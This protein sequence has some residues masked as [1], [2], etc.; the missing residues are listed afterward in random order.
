LTICQPRGR[1]PVAFIW[2]TP[3]RRTRW[4]G[5]LAGRR[6]LLYRVAARLPVRVSTDRN[7]RIRGSSA[8]FFVRHYD[9]GG[10]LRLRQT[11]AAHVAG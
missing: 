10:R 6:T 7:V 4:I 2:V 3:R 11:I 8:T 1:R 5:I 9:G